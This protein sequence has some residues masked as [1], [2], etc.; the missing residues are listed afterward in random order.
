MKHKHSDVLIAIAEGKTVQLLVSN[1][2]VN[3]E[4][5]THVSPLHKTYTE[6]KW[7]VKPENKQDYFVLLDAVR[8]NNIN[9]VSDDDASKANLKLTFD[10]ETGLL[11]SA[12]VLK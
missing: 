9:Y 2:W 12:E 10:G 1:T 4:E 5:F 7:R 11:K 6:F 8:R 3:Y